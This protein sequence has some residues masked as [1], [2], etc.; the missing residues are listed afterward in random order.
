[1]LQT[2]ILESVNCLPDFAVAPGPIRSGIVIIKDIV[3][4]TDL[5]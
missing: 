4:L 5:N 1:M 2:L 3:S